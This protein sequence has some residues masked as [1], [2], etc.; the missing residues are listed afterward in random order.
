M[1][2]QILKKK[3]KFRYQKRC[4]ELEL[5]CRSYGDQFEILVKDKRDI[6]SYLKKELELRNEQIFDLN[7]RLIGL[8]QAKN[9]EKDLLEKKL[10]DCKGKSRLEIE[11]LENENLLLSNLIFSYK[12]KL[13]NFYFRN[14]FNW[15]RR[16]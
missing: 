9:N 2:Y 3:L 10:E 5:M 6:S 1:H 16:I 15:F 14:T 7:D 12:K 13:N 8:Q 4:D 11:K